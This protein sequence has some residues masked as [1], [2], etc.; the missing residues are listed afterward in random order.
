MLFLLKVVATQLS[1]VLFDQHAP[2]RAVTSRSKK[3]LQDFH[4]VAPQKRTVTHERF[5][6]LVHNLSLC[7]S[8][9]PFLTIAH[10]SSLGLFPQKYVEPQPL[11]IIHNTLPDVVDALSEELLPSSIITVSTSAPEPKSTLEIIYEFLTNCDDAHCA[12]NELA[13]MLKLNEND[14]NEIEKL[15]TGQHDNPQWYK[16]RR[17]VITGTLVHDVRSRMDKLNKRNTID[18]STLVD[19]CL[20][21]RAH[22]KGNRDTRYGLANES[23][24]VD[25]YCAHMRTCHSNFS[26]KSC[27]LILDCDNCFLGASP[28]RIGSCDCHGSYIVEIKCPSSLQNKPAGSFK[29]L[30]YIT[31]GMSCLHLKK[32]HKYYSQVTLYMAVCKKLH[33]DFVVWSPN[34]IAIIP[35]EFD[36]LVW[37][38]LLTTSIIFFKQIVIPA[39]QSDMANIS[40]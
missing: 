9:V 27:G 6:T 38:N 13:S 39:V 15:T 3:R 23:K 7:Q 26:I 35:V 11:P 24:A 33:T 12:S 40:H 14:Q 18:A 34:D 31:S 20:A 21:T 1:N 4:P 30:P 8:D 32:S 17:A 5:V 25:A 29:D 36:A 10:S 37:H 22:F 2:D 19:R 16:Y 28:D